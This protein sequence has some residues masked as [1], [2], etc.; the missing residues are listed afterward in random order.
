MKKLISLLILVLSIFFIMMGCSSKNAVSSNMYSFTLEEQNQ[1][2][3]SAYESLEDSL[4]ND[5]ID[6]KKGEITGFKSSGEF[7]VFT[8]KNKKTKD[9]NNIETILVTFAVKKDSKLKPIQVY[10]NHNGE[11]LGFIT[12]SKKESSS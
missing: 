5:I 2:I 7:K 11:V 3:I 10:L 12:K 4:Q 9:I 1:L 8:D 6:S